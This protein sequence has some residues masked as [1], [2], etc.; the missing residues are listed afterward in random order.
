MDISLLKQLSE[1]LDVS[2]V[3][4]INGEKIQKEDI[5][6]KSDEIVEN[7]LSYADTKIKKNKI[8][9]TL[10]SILSII[11]FVFL[12]FV[13]FKAI[14]LNKYYVEQTSDSQKIIDGLSMD[15]TMTIYKKTISENE[16]LIEEN[17]KIRNDFES[18]AKI[19][20]VG[21][22]TKYVL[23]H[24]SDDLIA[25]FWIG[26][27]ELTY[28]NM[29]ASD[30]IIIFNEKDSGQFNNSD[31]KYFLLRNDINDDVDFLKYIKENYYAKSNLF[32]GI[33]EI[34]ENYALN[35][36]VSIALPNVESTTLITGDYS[37]YI[38]N[39]KNNI[40]EVHILRNDKSYNFMF[41]GEDYTSD[42]YIKDILSTLEIK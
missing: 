22:T 10:L 11:I 18:F 9:I 33:R 32:T 25:S 8:K 40:R 26:V 37:G 27:S 30:S 21:D 35:T 15:K 23:R 5:S 12:S 38:F 16:Y 3:E 36:F 41:I 14:I 20:E 28:I 13:I 31:R 7:T 29:F 4:L 42:E 17:I 6:I 1:C 24:E 39:L 34:K 2:I 19:D